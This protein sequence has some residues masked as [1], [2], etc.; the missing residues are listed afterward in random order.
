MYA[1]YT[2][3]DFHFRVIKKELQISCYKKWALDLTEL[4]PGLE[5]L[6]VEPSRPAGERAGKVFAR[7][8]ACVFVS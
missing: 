2:I 3:S 7:S 8:F 6:G 5:D 1:R 4:R